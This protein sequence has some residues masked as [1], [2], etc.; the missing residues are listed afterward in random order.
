M[1]EEIA[2]WKLHEAIGRRHF[3][4]HNGLPGLGSPTSCHIKSFQELGAKIR[5][6]TCAD[7][8]GSGHIFSSVHFN[9]NTCHAKFEFEDEEL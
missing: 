6:P 9:D 4:I 8:H 3:G 2:L 5:N 7:L 1:K